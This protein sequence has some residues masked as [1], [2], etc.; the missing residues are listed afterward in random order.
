MFK[1]WVNKLKLTTNIYSFNWTDDWGEKLPETYSLTRGSAVKE[2]STNRE[3][4]QTS[5]MHNVK[6]LD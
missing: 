6:T 1:K 3:D 4:R 2:R 5:Y